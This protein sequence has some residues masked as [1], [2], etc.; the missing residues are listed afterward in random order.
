M[1]E[2][3][4]KKFGGDHIPD[5][6]QYLREYIELEP[7]VTISIGCDSIQK[8][9]RTV[10]AITIMLYNGDLRNGA[11]VVFY[12]E[13]VPKIKNTF[14]RLRKE[15][16]YTQILGEY[17][18][19]N[20]SPFYTR[21]DLTLIER[22]RYKYHLLKSE[23]KCD[24][25][26]SHNEGSA[27]EHLILTEGEKQM[28]YKLIDIHLDFNPIEGTMDSKGVA[29]NRSNASYKALVPWIRGM[30][31]RVWAKNQSFASTSA[32]DLKLHD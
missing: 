10:Y 25:I 13:N 11:H 5:I 18:Q 2:V 22:R 21:N 16:D 15:A 23:G 29:K 14:E 17:L 31:Y 26:E 28:E 27:I 1:E 30:G 9:R 12:R 4:F 6:I 32:A 3:R 7:N 24:H 8:R 20:L 19:T